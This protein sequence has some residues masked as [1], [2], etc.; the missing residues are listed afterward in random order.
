[1]DSIKRPRFHGWA[2]ASRNKDANTALVSM[3]KIVVEE[4]TKQRSVFVILS[5]REAA[6]LY[7]SA[8]G[9]SSTFHKSSSFKGHSSKF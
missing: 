1:M 2:L 3:I 8:F 6:N 4:G 9:P 5:H 7:I